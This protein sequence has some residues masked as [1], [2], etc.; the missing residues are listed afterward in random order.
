[1]REVFGILCKAGKMA[2]IYGAPTK[3][4]VPCIVEVPYFNADFSLHCNI[5]YG[6]G[7][8]RKG[9]LT[10]LREQSPRPRKGNRAFPQWR[11]LEEELEEDGHGILGKPGKTSTDAEGEKPV[12]RQRRILFRS[13]T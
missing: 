4:N 2:W 5:S 11:R 13:V 12:M 10:V 7:K 6:E 1:M 9:T 8:L 3:I